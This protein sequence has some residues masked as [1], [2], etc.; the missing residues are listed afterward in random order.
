MRRL[1][2]IAAA[3]YSAAWLALLAL[4]LFGATLPEVPLR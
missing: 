1:L 3:C 4:A 2:L